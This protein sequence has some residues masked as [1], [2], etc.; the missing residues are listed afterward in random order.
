[1]AQGDRAAVDVDAV[2]VPAE[3]A[4]VGERLHGERLVGLD[5]V[6]VADGG[7]GL[8]HQVLHREDRREEELLRLAAA[9]GVAGDPRQRREA[10][11]LREGE[12]GHDQRARAVVE[13]RRVAR[14]H[15]AAVL[16]ERRLELGERLERWCP[17]AG[18][19]SVSTMV[20]P[21]LP[22]TSTGTISALNFPAS[23]AA[24]AF[25]WLS[26]AKRV[27]VLRG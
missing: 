25:W 7:A 23:I 9:G 16:L 26:K 20:G 8:L 21:F 4:A 1:M 27:L 14:R 13:A 18:D 22:G 11:R 6:V 2:P 17:C 10:V 3:R 19:S 12:R 5:Q 15:R 24:T